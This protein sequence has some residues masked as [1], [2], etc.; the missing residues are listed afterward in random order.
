MKSAPLDQ[1]LSRLREMSERSAGSLVELEIDSTRRLLDASSL[2]GESAAQWSAASAS[3]TDLWRW[4]EQLEELL[5]RAEKL[6]GP[7]RTAELQALLKGQSIELTPPEIPLAEREL[8]GGPEAAVR[9]SPDQLLQRMSR[10]FD[11]VKSVVARFG[12]A[13]ETFGP[14][15]EQARALAGEASSIATQLGEPDPPDLEAAKR[16]IGELT[17]ALTDDP[18]SVSEARVQAVLTTLREIRRDLHNGAAFK[19]ELEP[20]L[21][22][23]KEQLERLRTAVAAARAARD[24]LLVKIAVPAAAANEDTAAAAAPPPGPPDDLAAE[25]TAVANLARSGAW[26]D[27]GLKLNRW[28]TLAATR[29]GEATQAARAARAPVEARNQLRAMLEAYQVKAAR[30]G[31]IEEPRLERLFARAH[32]ALYTA[33]TDLAFAAPLVREYQEAL[34]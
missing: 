23:A 17:T 13:W 20:R 28:S 7:R 15:L 10:A 4:R 22:I 31:L 33:P 29:L 8:L 27:A 26:R 16:T 34:R 32:E 12:E 18:L 25:L 30:I 1:D 6:R 11:H 2:T 14:G 24:E 19:A 3:L 5:G 9:C 21:A